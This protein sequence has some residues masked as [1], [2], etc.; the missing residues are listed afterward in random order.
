MLA[1]VFPG[2]GSQYLGMGK[3]FWEASSKAKEIFALAE[4]LTGIPVKR[5]VFEGPGRV[6]PYRKLTGFFNH[7]KHCNF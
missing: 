7:R 3:D 2:Q 6:N 4:E 1:L 5:L